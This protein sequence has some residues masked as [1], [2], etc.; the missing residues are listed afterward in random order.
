MKK[1]RDINGKSYTILKGTDICD[2]TLTPKTKGYFEQLMAID[3]SVYGGDEKGEDCEYV[4]DIEGYI[5]RFG[6]DEDGN[7]DPSKGVVDNIIAIA[8]P[9][10]DNEIIGYVNYLTMDD[11]LY[12]EII[13]PDINAYL[14]DPTRRDDGITGDQLRPWSKDK[15][16]NMFILSIAIDKK[17]QDGEAIKI[18]T[19][20]FLEELREKQKE[21][22]PVTSITCDTVSDHGEDAMKMFRCDNCKGKDGK[23]IILPAMESDESG[24]EVTVRICEGENMEKLLQKGFDLN[25]IRTANMNKNIHE[26]N[27]LS[28]DRQRMMDAEIGSQLSGG[29]DIDD[30]QFGE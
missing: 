27:H 17:Y 2:P 21:G 14:E 8:D 23:P 13:N 16:N 25:R 29:K 9:N 4:G 28:A 1:I 24:H 20:S 26:K 3:S 7:L 6:Y 19:D 11:R 10:K 5:N 12:E 15:P 30:K 22:Y 18:L